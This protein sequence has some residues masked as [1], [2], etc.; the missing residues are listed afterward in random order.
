MYPQDIIDDNHQ[1]DLIIS[2]ALW[3]LHSALVHELGHTTGIST[4]K[5]V[6]KGVLQHTADIPSAYMAALITDDDDT[7]LS[8]GTPHY[9]AI[10]H[11]FGRHGLAPGFT[12]TDIA[13][14]IIDKLNISIT[15]SPPASSDYPAS[16]IT[17]IRITWHADN[18]MPTTFD[19]APGTPWTDSFPTMPPDTVIGYTIEAIHDNGTN[20]M[21]PQNATDPEYQLFAGPAIPIYCQSMDT[22]PI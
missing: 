11:A 16:T 14:P 13:P 15:I 5:N 17:G 6:F 1:T 9:Y 19:L 4:T 12:D 20:L 18:G 8:N 22:D 10:E 3:D 21:F 2:N 7:D